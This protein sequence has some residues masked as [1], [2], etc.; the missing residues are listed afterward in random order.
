M[1][2]KE[3][4]VYE[5]DVNKKYLLSIYG[6]ASPEEL[7][8]LEKGLADWLADKSRPILLVNGE[9]VKLVKVEEE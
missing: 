2:R 1:K 4:P 8:R 5:I 7:L 9:R 3:L 6:H